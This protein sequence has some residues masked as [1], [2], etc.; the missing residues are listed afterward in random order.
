MAAAASTR[1]RYEIYID[2]CFDTYLP[3]RNSKVS[4]AEKEISAVALLY[5]AKIYGPLWETISEKANAYAL[6]KYEEI[7]TLRCNCMGCRSSTYKVVTDKISP[8]DKAK[9]LGNISLASCNH[10]SNS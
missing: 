2:S 7:M 9:Y 5:C 3:S 10:K 8:E 6:K 1:P 4:V